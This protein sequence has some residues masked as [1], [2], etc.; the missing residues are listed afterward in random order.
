MVK[1]TV[2][3][4]FEGRPLS[5]IEGE[6]IAKA[7]FDSGIRTLSY[8]VKYKRP[9]GIHCARG[10]CVACHVAV[11]GV[12]GVPSCITPLRSGM[13]IE[14]ENYLPIY[15]PLA[16]VAARVI[17]FPAGF[18]Y[19]MF[20]KPA[21]VQKLFL[22]TL[23]RMAGVGRINPREDDVASG[24][25]PPPARG[26]GLPVVSDYDL[27]IVGCGLSGMSAA[28]S[29]VHRGLQVLLVD[30]YA[31]PGGHSFGYQSEPELAAARDDLVGKVRAHFGIQYLP[32]VTAQGFYA[33]DT[34]LLGPGGSTGFDRYTGLPGGPSGSREISG[35][36]APSHSERTGMARVR[37]RSYIF[38]TGANDI[39]PL[40]ENNDT[41]G[42]FGERAVRLFLER[43]ELRPGRR[44]VVYG[45]GQALRV[46]AQLLL[47]HDIKLIALVDPMRSE[48]SDEHARRSLDKIRTI[49]EAKITAARGKEWLR[50]V[51]V[52]RDPGGERTSLACD[53][54]CM[55]LPGQ[56]AFELPYQAGISYSLSYS[57]L[58]EFRVMIP[59]TLRSAN[60][61][62]PTSIF[63][64]GDAAG[65]TDWR[66]K[67]EAGA[68]AGT[69]AARLVRK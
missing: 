68:Q 26:E 31:S 55:A 61:G 15:G 33:P 43:D 19:R 10:R 44:A 57:N 1:R 23:R 20:T 5:G 9:R 21:I 2:T 62:A 50:G 28:L 29:A 48:K 56:P 54:L 37:A 59:D 53:L 40:F 39:V 49:S 6:S 17:P 46:T 22:G 12:P 30:E 51:E 35:A 8:S 45:T 42:I 4:H 67:I 18:Y 69:E 16:T 66:R 3:F 41:P 52:S 25:A 60:A 27:V 32:C 34:L 11:D 64:V 63:V 47:H 36:L 38:A 13:R 58:D 65:E 14:R 24:A 7:L